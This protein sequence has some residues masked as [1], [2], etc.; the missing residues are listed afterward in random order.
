M[1]K[2]LGKFRTDKDNEEFRNELKEDKLDTFVQSTEEEATL[3]KFKEMVRDEEDQIVKAFKDKENKLNKL[4]NNVKKLRN[5][6]EENNDKIINKE[7]ELDT[8]KNE[9]D[10]LL[11]KLNQSNEEL[12]RTRNELFET[13]KN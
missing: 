7:K 13:K 8:V 11:L 6:V 9:R 12:N 5:Y 3:N 2:L 1:F 4:N 10:V